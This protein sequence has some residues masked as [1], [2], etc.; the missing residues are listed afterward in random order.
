MEEAFRENPQVL[1]LLVGSPLC[2]ACAFA[3]QLPGYLSALAPGVAVLLCCLLL[4]RPRKVVKKD[5][6]WP[7]ARE[8]QGLEAMEDG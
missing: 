3:G 1:L 4:E 6:R 7:Q 8:S 5:A 2:W